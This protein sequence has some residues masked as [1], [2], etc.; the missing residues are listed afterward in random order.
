VKAVAA[1]LEADELEPDAKAQ[2]L[3]GIIVVDGIEQLAVEFAADTI[4]KSCSSDEFELESV[5]PIAGT[6]GAVEFMPIVRSKGLSARHVMIIG[7]DDVNLSWTTPQAVFVAL[8][9]ARESL[10]LLTTLRVRGTVP[11]SYLADLPPRSIAT[12]GGLRRAITR[13]RSWPTAA[14]SLD[15]SS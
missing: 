11:H 6:M 10:H 7:C 1:A 8:T 4:G 14:N 12:I 9:R 13:S 5:L 2:Q 3:V 15:G